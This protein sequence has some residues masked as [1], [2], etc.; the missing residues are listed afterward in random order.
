MKAQARQSFLR[1]L[2]L[3]PNNTS[4]MPNFSILEVRH[5]RLDEAACW[6]RRLFPLSGKRGNDYHHLAVPFMTLRADA[7]SRTVL[8]AA[9]RRF[10][11]FPRIQTTLATLELFEGK[12][13]QAIARMNAIAAREAQNEEV[14]R[15]RP[16]FAVLTNSGNL[17]EALEPLMQYSASTA[18]ALGPTVRLRYAWLL[19]KREGAARAAPLVAEAERIA[20]A[21]I[22]AGS[23]EARVRIEMAGAAALRKDPAAALDWLSRAYD[24][25]YRDFVFLARDPIFGELHSNPRFGAILDRI[26]NDVAAQRRRAEQRGLLR[27]DDLLTPSK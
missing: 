1:A 12:D 20:R 19:G 23:E 11:V 3:D 2:E 13:G 22:D 7:L 24:T 8:E 6:G 25:G 16:E 4:A 15:L 5:G 10:P 18:L 26:R 21:Q 17:P 9:E 27:V 14:R